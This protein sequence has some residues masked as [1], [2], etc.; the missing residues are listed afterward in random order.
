MK[1][2]INTTEG[3]QIKIA[4]KSLKGRVISEKKIE[5]PYQQ[6]EKLLPLVESL[7][8]EN[9]KMMRDL[10]EIVVV[11]IGGSFTSLRIG[12]VTANALGYALGIPVKGTNEQAKKDSGKF[13]IVEPVYSSEPNITKERK[14][15]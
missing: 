1:L 9:N 2:I 13:D 10:K 7:L 6:S 4:L 14:K 8:N 5:A 11:N 12:I 15:I 3:D